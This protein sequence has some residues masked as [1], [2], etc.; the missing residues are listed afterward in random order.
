MVYPKNTKKENRR[1]VQVRIL[2]PPLR[3]GDEIVVRGTG[4]EGNGLERRWRGEMV[5]GSDVGRDKR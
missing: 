3:E 4:K 5:F 1:K 2:Q